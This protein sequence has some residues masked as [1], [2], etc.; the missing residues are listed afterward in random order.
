MK[1][2]TWAGPS[3]EGSPS[4]TNLFYKNRLLL[5][6]EVDDLLQGQKMIKKFRR[7]TS[8]PSLIYFNTVFEIDFVFLG[9]TIFK[10]I[11]QYFR[12]K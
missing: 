9:F 8:I 7:Q 4:P 10:Q 6:V 12:K 5:L 1:K 2:M 3:S 11:F